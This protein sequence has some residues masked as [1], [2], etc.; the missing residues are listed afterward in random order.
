[1][2]HFGPR[3]STSPNIQSNKLENNYRLT[4]LT[5]TKTMITLLP[6]E[7]NRSTPEKT[8]Q[9]FPHPLSYA[10]MANP[11]QL[12]P[13]IPDPMRRGHKHKDPRTYFPSKRIRKEQMFMGLIV[14]P[15]K[16]TRQRNRP[17]PPT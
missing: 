4:N 17:I 5:F 13:P 16:N 8:P 14:P 11:R 15:T 7:V 9:L 2:N 6:N 3:S 10:L 12:N 1:M